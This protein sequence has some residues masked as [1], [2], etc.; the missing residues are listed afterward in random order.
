VSEVI[1]I[2]NDITAL[3]TIKQTNRTVTDKLIKKSC[4]KDFVSTWSEAVLEKGL[5]LD[6]F[7]ETLVHE[8]ILVTA[9]C[10]DSIMFVLS[11]NPTSG[12]PWVCTVSPLS[13]SDPVFKGKKI[14]VFIF[15]KK[16]KKN[17]LTSDLT[18]DWFIIPSKLRSKGNK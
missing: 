3:G 2:D 4:H 13:P 1:E 8:D 15:L 9:Q 14:G 12:V 5:T 18:R 6:F 10:T 11:V 7:C 17:G 16:M